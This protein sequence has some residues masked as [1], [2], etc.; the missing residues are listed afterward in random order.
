MTCVKDLIKALDFY[1]CVLGFTP[2]YLEEFKKAAFTVCYLTRITR[3]QL[4]QDDD[5]RKHWVLSQPW[6]LCKNAHRHGKNVTLGLP[7]ADDSRKTV[8]RKSCHSQPIH[9]TIC[10]K[11]TRCWRS[12][13]SNFT[14]RPRVLKA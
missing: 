4:L 11:I 6:L 1:A 8:C 10:F 3:D 7:A 14:L 2:V 13:N 5:E 12:L 9:W